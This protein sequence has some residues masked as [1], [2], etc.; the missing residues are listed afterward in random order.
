MERVASVRK[1]RMSG[2]PGSGVPSCVLLRSY[3]STTLKITKLFIFRGAEPQDNE[4][5]K[6]M[7]ILGRNRRRST[8]ELSGNSH[9]ACARRRNVST[10]LLSAI[11]YAMVSWSFCWSARGMVIGLFRRAQS[12]ET[13]I[14]RMRMPR[15]NEKAGEK[16]GAGPKPFVSYLH[17]KPRQARSN[18]GVV[19]VDAHLCELSNWLLPRNNIV[20]RPASHRAKRRLREMRQ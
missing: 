15:L 13:E 18:A 5:G 1:P 20:I 10:W 7:P 14:G 9:F 8:L 17:R 12:M 4:Y 16:C 3:K 6:L 11:G 19:L 2:Q